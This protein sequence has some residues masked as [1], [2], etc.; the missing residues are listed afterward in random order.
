M[1]LLIREPA[2][3]AEVFSHGVNEDKCWGVI[4]VA[5]CVTFGKQRETNLNVPRISH[6]G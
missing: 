1:I 6:S 2:D 4:P 5:D 3:D